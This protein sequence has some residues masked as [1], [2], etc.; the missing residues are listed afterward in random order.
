MGI[1]FSRDFMVLG[2]GMLIPCNVC[3]AAGGDMAGGSSR[4]L[5]SWGFRVFRVL[6]FRCSGFRV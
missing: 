5:V 4:L 2:I 1:P 6:G 3:K